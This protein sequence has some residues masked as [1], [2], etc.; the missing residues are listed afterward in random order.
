MSI[1]NGLIRCILVFG[2]LIASA[3]P[4]SYALPEGDLGVA[5]FPDE[6]LSDFGVAPGDS[7]PFTLFYYWFGNTSAHNVK[8]S[9]NF[10]AGTRIVSTSSTPSSQSD[11]TL[12]WN[13]GSLDTIASDAFKIVVIVGPG[14]VEGAEFKV[15]ASISGDVADADTETNTASL[16]FK[17]AKRLPDLFVFKWGL[18]EEQYVSEGFFFV[19]D[20]EMPSEFKIQ[21]YNMGPADAPDVKI[22]DELPPG[23]EFVSAEPAPTR[24][25]GGVLEWDLGVLTSFGSGDIKVR[26]VP[27]QSGVFTLRTTISTTAEEGT[28]DG[29]VER[30][31]NENECSLQVVSLMLPVVLQPA[32]K[33]DGGVLVITPNPQI[34]GHAKEG[35]TVAMYEGPEDHFGDDISGM[36]L[37]GRA[38]AGGGPGES[39]VWR[40]QPETLNESR[41]YY[42]YFRAEK[43]GKASGFTRP[44]HIK[45]NTALAEAGF[46]MDGFTVKTGG[47]ENKPGGLG[48]TTGAVPNEEVTIILRQAA[49]D[50]FDTNTDLWEYHKLKITIDDNG[51]ITKSTVPVF[52]VVRAGENPENSFKPVSRA[53]QAGI[54]SKSSF[55]LWDIIYKIPKLGPAVKVFVEF[56]PVKYD[57][58]TKEPEYVGEEDLL[59]TE[60]LI[61]PAGYVYD[62]EAAGKEYIW[63]EIPPETSL[64]DQATVTAYVRQGDY[65]WPEWDAPRYNQVNPQITDTVAEDQ[66]KNA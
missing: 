4:R 30:M 38:I 25:S 11:N 24:V 23:V 40:M 10:P 48:G 21:Y 6:M 35:A 29:G 17:V 7:V 65:D 57:E 63:P 12:A 19:T 1:R 3:A 27:L 58:T 54:N 44:L 59:I 34:M 13:F 31:P 61:D 36:R 20:L 50:G 28:I 14:I 64:I 32:S 52:R 33:K 39:R 60:I 51:V 18:M 37:M 41:D 66:V 8:L 47:G 53:G 16:T 2:F 49:P 42:L 5:L 62:L 26:V 15:S 43:D 55:S 9:V 22:R 45:I 46:D 56:K